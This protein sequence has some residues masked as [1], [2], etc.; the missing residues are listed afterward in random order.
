MQLIIIINELLWKNNKER[1][2]YLKNN[3]WND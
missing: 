2:P 1:I 3:T